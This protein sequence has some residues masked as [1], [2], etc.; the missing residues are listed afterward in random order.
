M[1]AARR[2]LP[3]AGL[4]GAL[5]AERPALADRAAGERPAL[6]LPPEPRRTHGWALRAREAPRRQPLAGE[7]PRPEEEEEMR[8]GGVARPGWCE[9][10]PREEGL[11]ATGGRVVARPRLPASEESRR[12]EE[13]EFQLIQKERECISSPSCVE[14]KGLPQNLEESPAKV[15]VASE[16]QSSLTKEAP[17][18]KADGTRLYCKTG[19]HG[20]R[21]RTGILPEASWCSGGDTVM[22]RVAV[23]G[24]DSLVSQEPLSP[25]SPEEEEGGGGLSTHAKQAGEET[26]QN[27]GQEIN[28]IFNNCPSVQQDTFS[29]HS[30]S[31]LALAL[32][33]GPPGMSS[34]A[35][36]HTFQGSSTFGNSPWGECMDLSEVACEVQEKSFKSSQSCEKGELLEEWASELNM[37]EALLQARSPEGELSNSDD[38]EQKGDDSMDPSH[39]CAH[40]G[41]VEIQKGSAVQHCWKEDGRFHSEHGRFP[42]PAEQL[43][44]PKD[45]H[46][47]IGT[48]SLC[49]VVQASS[50]DDLRIGSS[51]AGSIQ[52]DKASFLRHERLITIAKENQT[53]LLKG[54]NFGCF[55]NNCHISI[56]SLCSYL[57]HHLD[58]REND[59]PRV[60]SKDNLGTATLICDLALPLCATNSSS[61]IDVNLFT[62]NKSL[63][64]PSLCD[65]RPFTTKAN[66]R[67]GHG[68]PLDSRSPKEA[69]VVRSIGP[70]LHHK[71]G[72][73][74]GQNSGGCAEMNKGAWEMA[75]HMPSRAEKGNPGMGGLWRKASCSGDQGTNDLCPAT[76]EFCTLSRNLFSDYNH[77]QEGRRGTATKI[78]YGLGTSPSPFASNGKFTSLQKC[79]NTA[80]SCSLYGDNRVDPDGAGSTL[81]SV[82]SL[83]APCSNLS[84]AGTSRAEAENRSADGDETFDNSEGILGVSS[85]IFPPCERVEVNRASFGADAGGMKTT[86]SVIVR[87]NTSTPSPYLPLALDGDLNKTLH[88]CE[89]RVRKDQNLEEQEKYQIHPSSW[90]PN[91]SV[92]K[93]KDPSLRTKVSARQRESIYRMKILLY[94]RYVLDSYSLF[95]QKND[96]PEREFLECQQP[97]L[98]FCKKI[99]Y[100][101]LQTLIS[102]A[103][104]YIRCKENKSVHSKIDHKVTPPVTA[105]LTEYDQNAFQQNT[106]GEE[107]SSDLGSELTGDLL[108][109]DSAESQGTRIPLGCLERTF[110]LL[111]Q[112]DFGKNQAPRS[113]ADERNSASESVSKSPSEKLNFKNGLFSD[114][115]LASSP[116]QTSFQTGP[117]ISAKIKGQKSKKG[118][119]L[120]SHG[121][122]ELST[123]IYTGLGLQFPQNKKICLSQKD[124][125]LAL[126]SLEA[127]SSPLAKEHFLVTV[128]L[129]R[130]A[131]CHVKLLGFETERAS[132]FV[133][134]GSLVDC[135]PAIEGAKRESGGV[136]EI[137]SI[138][139]NT[140]EQSLEAKQN[141]EAAQREAGQTAGMTEFPILILSDTEGSPEALLEDLMFPFRGGKVTFSFKDAVH[142]RLPLCLREDISGFDSRKAKDSSEPTITQWHAENLSY[143]LQMKPLFSS[144]KPA[145]CLGSSMS[146]SSLEDGILESSSRRLSSKEGHFLRV[147]STQELA[148]GPEEV[149]EGHFVGESVRRR[150]S[151]AGAQPPPQKEKPKVKRRLTAGQPLASFSDENAGRPEDPGQ[152]ALAPGGGGVQKRK[153]ESPFHAGSKSK[154]QKRGQ[155][156]RESTSLNLCLRGHSQRAKGWPNSVPAFSTLPQAVGCLQSRSQDAFGCSRPVRPF[157]PFRKLSGTACTKVG[158]PSQLRAPK[159]LPLTSRSS[160]LKG[161]PEIVPEENGELIYSAQLAAK[162]AAPPTPKAVLWDQLAKQ[163]G[164]Q[165]SLL[166]S[167]WLGGRPKDAALLMRLSVLAET[168][169]APKGKP[170]LHCGA[171]LPSAE[172]RSQLRRR[173]L[174]EI[175]SFVSLKLNSHHWLNSG[176]C[177]FKMASSR[178]LSVYSIESTILCFFELSNESPCV[179]ST[180]VF[181]VSFH[182]PMDTSPTRKAPETG[183]PGP[184][185][186]LALGG[187]LPQQPW[188]RSLSFLLPRSCPGPTP[189]LKDAEP[190]SMSAPRG[191]RAVAQSTGSPTRGLPTAL[192]LFS[193]SCYRVWMRKRHLS[194]RTPTVRR[195]ILLQFAQGL[196]GLRHGTFVSADLF[197]SVPHLLG[198]VLPIWSQHGPSAHLSE[199][200]PLH[201]TPCKGQPASP[202][203][204][205]LGH[206]NRLEPFLSVLLP[207]S[208]SAPEPAHSLLG[209]PALGSGDKHDA[210][211]PALPKAGTQL[212]KDESENRPKKVSQIRIRKTIPK[213]D[214][215]LTPMGL[216]R[217]KR[218]KKTEFSLEEIYTN[219]NYKSPPT[220]RCLETIFE[221]PKEKNGSLISISQQKRKRILEFQDFTIPRKRK[222]RSRVRAMGGYTRAQKA[223]I[224][225]RELDILLIQKL[226]DLEM[227]FAKE[228]KQEQATGS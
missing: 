107:S 27:Q 175:F 78:S 158:V 185:S 180:P 39:S 28:A 108:K 226:T 56:P 192:A 23:S 223:A 147:E 134:R 100:H 45:V 156:C 38:T 172:K 12:S 207:T 159:N 14:I 13:K 189:I 174:L 140:L 87:N 93:Q 123:L 111:N 25:A 15:Q 225:G 60:E 102:S 114:S 117:K 135:L 76:E 48:S 11:A 195:L 167:L 119:H 216:P 198:R 35:T 75:K 5:P 122:R 72:F 187:P 106:L 131:D 146:S 88:L 94:S 193:P 183:P 182:H 219:K 1:S 125:A 168:L 2:E 157:P 109:E 113:K 41:T 84:K 85:D 37:A 86:E 143:T 162:P 215:N 160:V 211:V 26:F 24:A 221:E 36:G 69:L 34:E 201:S 208:C 129:E 190:S 214:P 179:C 31:S 210:S 29:M 171:L 163:Q 213:P 142:T 83:D 40:E 203:A 54:N 4:P 89:A 18:M 43:A 32:D 184:V 217:P 19:E 110:E 222:A 205:G 173:K 82:Y 200:T 66:S 138:S 191:R 118:L 74:S 139:S 228:E 96:S 58:F 197:S 153:R 16:K 49:D 170:F 9:G 112:N 57:D 126:P 206:K 99:D 155:G 92:L 178:A 21:A 194:S 81:G 63:K 209:F 67:L 73:A 68:G 65:R 199:F 120:R 101:D 46:S 224:E 51:E 70:L 53:L 130:E 218:L 62:S 176:S 104:K 161:P 79:C 90:A 61:V 3:A 80:C 97:S 145:E 115:K 64:I 149:W 91:L 212:E 141:L 55:Q 186:R 204:T 220:T 165:S 188:R 202:A 196:K 10:D 95:E 59:L 17:G 33:A 181:P 169:L 47:R 50:E 30:N 148:A 227:F 150:D 137:G 22:A 77:L 177:C 152:Q 128:V 98:I 71:K 132:S 124:E 42:I 20:A 127:H 154:R 121:K 116:N 151:E 166:A 8:G 7:A 164:N 136:E 133:R 144:R 105:L 44:M 103:V 6:G 52:E